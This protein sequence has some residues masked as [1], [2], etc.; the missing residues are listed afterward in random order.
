MKKLRIEDFTIEKINITAAYLQNLIESG[1]RLV[2]LNGELGAG[3]TH[4]VAATINLLAGMEINVTSPTFSLI[5]IYNV[6]KLGKVVH[7]D[8]Y[9]I[10]SVSE[11][12]NVGLDDII[13]SRVTFIEWPDIIL[14]DLHKYFENAIVVNIK[15]DQ[16]YH[17]TIEIEAIQLK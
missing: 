10:N 15:I 4:L 17:R 16:S 8:L 3:K 6:V 14:P 7:L 11:M 13:D 12:I 1:N 5:N 9:R 2:L